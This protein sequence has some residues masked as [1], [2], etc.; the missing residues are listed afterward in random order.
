LSQAEAVL[1]TIQ[2]KSEAGLRMAQRHLRGELGVQVSG[3]RRCLLGLL[4]RLEA[5]IDFSEEDITFVETN[6]LCTSLT[7]IN[8]Y[9]VE[10]GEAGYQTERWG[11]SG[12]RGSAECG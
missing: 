11:T 4:S 7:E 6:E 1:D 9:D 8:R 5:G 10:A 12:H 2:A 3:L